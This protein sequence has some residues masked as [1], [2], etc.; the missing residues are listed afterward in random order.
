M[1]SRRAR[2]ARCSASA[3]PR[4]SALEPT[5]DPD[6]RFRCRGH[7]RLHGRRI[8]GRGG[9]GV[10][11]RAR[12]ASGGD[13]AQ[14]HDL[15]QGRGGEGLPPD[16]ECRSRRPGP[17]GLR[18]RRPEGAFGAGH[19]RHIQTPAGAGDRHRP[20]GERPALV[21][22]SQGGDRYGAGRHLAGD[23]RPGRRAMEGV[24]AG[25]RDRLR[26][27]SG[28]RRAGTG[29]DPAYE[30]RPFYAG[31]TG[32]QCVRAGRAAV[33]TDDRGR[34]EGAAEAAAAR[35]DL[36]Q[37]VG[38]LFVQSGLRADR[39]KPR[40]DRQRRGLPRRDP[41]DDAGMQT[42]R[43]SGRRAFLRRCRKTDRRR[44][45]HRRAQTL[46]PARCREG[47]ADGTGRPRVGGAGT[48]AA[49][50]DRDT[51]AGYGCGPGAHA[52]RCAGALPAQSGPGSGPYRGRR[53]GVIT[54]L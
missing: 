11:G 8:V 45:D 7:R 17:A 29:C 12:P 14:R 34:L 26:R 39:R 36:D 47:A 27:L 1:R 6:L 48:G 50:R 22:L 19:R 2:P 30:R 53:G 24:R 9:G 42:G 44:G 13:P 46:D 41:V 18:H 49:A 3:L 5:H 32:R 21:V 4:N 31:R 23:G 15:P 25:A 40:P 54:P 37:V 16:R 20:G 33:E 52:G 28:L 35:R 43:R 38:E 51:H 10:A